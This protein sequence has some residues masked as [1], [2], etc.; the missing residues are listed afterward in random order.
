MHRKNLNILAPTIHRHHNYSQHRYFT[1]RTL[2]APT[3]R[4]FYNHLGY[5]NFVHSS[6]CHYHHSFIALVRWCLKVRELQEGLHTIQLQ[7]QHVFYDNLIGRIA[8]YISTGNYPWDTLFL[9]E[10]VM[11]GKGW[12]VQGQPSPVNNHKE[13]LYTI[14][15]SLPISILLIFQMP[16][17][18]RPSDPCPH[19]TN[20]H[21]STH[22]SDSC[23]G[24]YRLQ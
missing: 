16:K 7:L 14:I 5:H 1:L 10:L 19:N 17:R 3:H 23:M 4:I 13:P 12:G 20:V 21:L 9:Q 18:I 22:L 11:E 2:P 6:Y 15:Q 8:S 24:M